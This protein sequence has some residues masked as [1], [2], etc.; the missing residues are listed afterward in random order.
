MEN[1]TRACTVVVTDT[2]TLE[3]VNQQGNLQF[4]VP[5]TASIIRFNRLPV[6]IASSCEACLRW[7]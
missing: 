3:F 1:S 6:N 5:Q 2:I 4:K 7:L